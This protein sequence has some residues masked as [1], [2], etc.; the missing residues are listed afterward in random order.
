MTANLKWEISKILDQIQIVNH[1]FRKDF[2]GLYIPSLMQGESVQFHKSAKYFNAAV[3]L[4]SNT[5][6]IQDF[7]REVELNYKFVAILLLTLMPKKKL[8]I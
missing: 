3:K 4:D 6:R 1:A 5:K 7:Y 8:R 2:I